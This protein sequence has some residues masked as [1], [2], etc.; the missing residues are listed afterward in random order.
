[1]SGKPSTRASH[2]ILFLLQGRAATERPH[3]LLDDYLPDTQNIKTAIDN[4]YHTWLLDPRS[5]YVHESHER[6]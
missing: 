3:A 1:M 4:A 5:N 2:N 6:S